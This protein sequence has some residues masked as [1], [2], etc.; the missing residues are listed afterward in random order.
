MIRQLRGLMAPLLLILAALSFV[1]SSPAHAAD[2]LDAPF[3]RQDGQTD[4]NDMYIFHPGSPQ[5]L[6]RTVL[7]MTVNPAAGVN[8]PT[9]FSTNATYDFLI[10]QNG[11]ARED[12]TFRAGFS[13]GGSSQQITLSLEDNGSSQILASGPVETTIQGS[14]GVLLF[15]GVR[16]DPFF[17]DLDGFNDGLAFCNGI[18]GEDFFLGLNVSAIVIDVPSSLLGSGQIGFWGVTRA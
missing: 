6:S 14:G 1:C 3:V 4:I 10:D 8:S 9:S 12:L 5:D 13:G 2:H 15:A 17:F 7:V 16:D 11:D 18:V